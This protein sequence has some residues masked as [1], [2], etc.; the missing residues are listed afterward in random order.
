[1]YKHRYK[2]SSRQYIHVYCHV[3]HTYVL[4]HVFLSP[5]L[6]KAIGNLFDS[7][8]PESLA[9]DYQT[10][11]DLPKAEAAVARDKAEKDAIQKQKDDRALVIYSI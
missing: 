4:L 3:D 2:F 10:E 6:F 1:M 8:Q 11:F 9:L 7:S 5:G